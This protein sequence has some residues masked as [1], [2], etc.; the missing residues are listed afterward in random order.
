MPGVGDVK[1]SH[2]R[3]LEMP[4]YE[5]PKRRITQNVEYRGFDSREMEQ[6]GPFDIRSPEMMKC[7]NLKRHITRNVE[8]QDFG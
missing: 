1:N 7:E 5:N 2:I 3:S 4:K 8:Y 6:Q